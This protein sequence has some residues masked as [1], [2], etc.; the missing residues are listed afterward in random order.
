[1]IYQLHHQSKV[2]GTK[3]EFC[4]QKEIEPEPNQG[5]F[6]QWFNDVTARF[7]IPDGFQWLCCLEDSEYFIKQAVE[8]G[9][10]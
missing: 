9:V 1:M 3:T 6:M 8:K 2:D 4:S 5:E 7:P 10:T